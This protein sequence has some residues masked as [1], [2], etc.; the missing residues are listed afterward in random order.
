VV[1][2]IETDGVRRQC[3]AGRNGLALVKLR[4]EITLGTYAHV[5][6]SM[7]QDAASR[8]GALWHGR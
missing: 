8:L 4:V 1:T 6:P 2:G 3:G 7:Q 5:L